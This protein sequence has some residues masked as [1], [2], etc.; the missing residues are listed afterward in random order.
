MEALQ[1]QADKVDSLIAQIVEVDV[2]LDVMPDDQLIKVDPKYYR[3]LLQF[4]L[5]SEHAHLCNLHRLHEY[6]TTRE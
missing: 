4:S 2:L 3:K 1:A 5:D 6:Q